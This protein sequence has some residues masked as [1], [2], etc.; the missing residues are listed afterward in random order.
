MHRYLVEICSIVLCTATV[1]FILQIPAQAQTENRYWSGIVLATSYGEEIPEDGDIE[2]NDADD[3][4]MPDSSFTASDHSGGQI[5]VWSRQNRYGAEVQFRSFQKV[6][7]QI[8][9]HSG[10]PQWNWETQ[11]HADSNGGV[12]A[13]D[14]SMLSQQRAPLCASD[15]AHGCFVIWR[16]FKIPP[17]NQDTVEEYVYAQHFDQDGNRTFPDTGLNLTPL[18]MNAEN[19]KVLGYWIDATTEGHAIVVVAVQSPGVDYGDVWAIRVSSSGIDWSTRV[20][21]ASTC[22]QPYVLHDHAGGAYVAWNDARNGLGV[23]ADRV[24]EDGN[25]LWDD[26]TF[27]GKVVAD[28]LSY[29][30]TIRDFGITCGSTSTNPVLL[31]SSDCD[32]TVNYWLVQLNAS[33]G[34]RISDWPI[35]ISAGNRTIAHSASDG[36]GNV[37]ASSCTQTSISGGLAN[38]DNFCKVDYVAYDRTSN[39]GN[40]WNTTVG[41]SNS[42][43]ECTD[44]RVV[45]DGSTGCVVSW[46]SVM[47]TSATDRNPYIRAQKLDASGSEVWTSGGIVAL[48]TAPIEGGQFGFPS[49]LYPMPCEDGS[50][51]IFLSWLL[52]QDSLLGY[53]VLPNYA[54]FERRALFVQRL[55]GDNSGH[56]AFV[57]AQISARRYGVD[58]P[59]VSLAK[60]DG[61]TWL[62][63]L[64]RSLLDTLQDT[65]NEESHFDIRIQHLDPYGIRY[66]S[67]NGEVVP[68]SQNAIGCYSPWQFPED[69][70]HRTFDAVDDEDSTRPQGVVYKSNGMV[71][72][73]SGHGSQYGQPDL[74]VSHVDH[75]GRSLWNDG[76]SPPN[77][78]ITMGAVN[79]SWQMRG[80]PRIVRSVDTVASPPVP[81]YLIAWVEETAQNNSSSAAGPYY[82]IMSQGVRDD[83]NNAPTLFEYEFRDN[84]AIYNQALS[85]DDSCGNDNSLDVAFPH[86]CRDLYGGAWVAWMD[87]TDHP[88]PLRTVAVRHVGLYPTSDLQNH[89]RTLTNR[90]KWYDVQ[91]VFLR[92]DTSYADGYE[93]RLCTDSSLG[94]STNQDDPPPPR[95]PATPPPPTMTPCTAGCYVAFT[96]SKYWGTG[97]EA[98]SHI[99]LARVSCERYTPTPFTYCGNNSFWRSPYLIANITDTLTSPVATTFRQDRPRIAY[100]RD[101]S[102]P[103]AREC[104]VS[105]DTYNTQTGEYNITA[106]RCQLNALTGGPLYKYWGFNGHTVE[107]SDS[108]I[109]NRQ[110]VVTRGPNPVFSWIRHDANMTI[111]DSVLVPV[112]NLRAGKYA[113]SNANN[114]WTENVVLSDFY[115]SAA[116]ECGYQSDLSS[117]IDSTVVGGLVDFR[118][119]TTDCSSRACVILA[120]RLTSPGGEFA[121]PSFPAIN[122]DAQGTESKALLAGYPNP[123]HGAIALAYLLPKSGSVKLQLRDVLGREVW[124][125]SADLQSAGQHSVAA[126][127]GSERAGVYFAVLELEGQRLLKQLL[128]VH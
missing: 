123:S 42:Y 93:F 15:G 33:S 96:S 108:I 121:K 59:V 105:W 22:F 38:A 47:S 63:W 27:L 80:Q 8:I 30:E 110:C 99:W 101:A 127:I 28:S 120:Q 41:A 70:H 31:Y 118:F 82:T 39:S 11:E 36:D 112:F 16:E 23:Y 114:L 71:V 6:H 10:V 14:S 89:A 18:G 9:N 58:G 125:Y 67:D 98:N 52:K 69:A 40:D 21:L 76:G 77:P 2:A 88:A 106:Q 109:E 55:D 126:D 72:V 43:V 53:F 20:T 113:T 79:A 75:M 34:A 117:L 83:E 35:A 84:N 65:I 119:S 32:T 122:G 91:T 51:G 13:T 95:P 104:I 78:W 111:C 102:A 54:H 73:W 50:G 124:S 68:G 25:V 94:A 81:W 26:S 56:L 86:I 24:D 115:G 92:P 62:V 74:F 60:S 97:D 5:I 46:L 1:C 29:S 107:M 49:I 12:R 45:S 19:A 66:L 90:V 103:S 100:V 17:A 37:F 116:K 7:A 87:A 4:C 48:H 61:T 128:V 3:V 64:H 57:N 85:Q 44:S